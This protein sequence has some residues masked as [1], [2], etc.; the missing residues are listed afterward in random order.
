MS[1]TIRYWYD[2]KEY[3]R[4]LPDAKDT[5]LPGVHWG[6]FTSLFTPA[7][8][9]SQFW[10][11]GY[12]QS[13]PIASRLKS[14]DLIEEAVFCLLGGYGI[15]AEMAQSVFIECK[16]N[17]LISEKE[18]SEEKWAKQ[19]SQKFMVNGK[20]VSYRFPNQKAKYIS[21]AMPKLKSI[22][23]ELKGKELRNALQQISGIGPKTAGW[24][25][26]NCFGSDEVAIIDIHIQ[27]AG[28]LCGLFSLTWTADRH[29]T[30]ME[31]SFLDL[32]SQL[33]VKP[34][35][36]DFLIWEQMRKIGNI[37]IESVKRMMHTRKEFI[38]PIR[39]VS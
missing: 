30:R 4:E 15:S 20:L 2:H 38:E 12:E 8:W 36:F 35:I 29:Y 1:Q 34:S 28:Q 22:D 10:M 18:E 6:E 13:E 26:R 27:R 14:G 9:L 23:Q 25:V 31:E 5:V 3:T 21:Q 17:H 19:L 7:Y 32:C 16:N 24:I 33:C 37:A 11:N 39:V